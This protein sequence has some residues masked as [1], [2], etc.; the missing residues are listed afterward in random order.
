MLH[1]L[2]DLNL[3]TVPGQLQ[4][5]RHDA[6]FFSTTALP[7]FRLVATAS[8]ACEGVETLAGFVG[9]AHLDIHN[10]VTA[11]LAMVRRRSDG[12]RVRSAAGRKPVRSNCLCRLDLPGRRYSDFAVFQLE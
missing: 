1:C 6:S 8:R 4:V 5:M 9:T 12:N 2:L 7:G 11:A 10:R 3:I